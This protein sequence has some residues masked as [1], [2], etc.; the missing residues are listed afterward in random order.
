MSEVV[1]TDQS[2]HEPSTAHLHPLET[3]PQGSQSEGI[4]F[5]HEHH[6]VEVGILA[7]S[8]I[9]LMLL[10]LGSFII[11]WFVVIG[12]LNSLKAH[13]AAPSATY[14][15]RPALKR[16]WPFPPLVAELQP[17]GEAPDLQPEPDKPMVMLREKQEADLDTY[18]W[19]KD[20]KGRTI[21]VTLKIDRAM[22]LALERGLPVEQ[23][24][25]PHILPPTSPVVALG[26]IPAS[27][28]VIR[29]MEL[30]PNKKSEAGAAA[31]H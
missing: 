14:A 31:K 20:E 30:N 27:E 17:V 2:F 15:E 3:I 12:L 5:G 21:G 8:V 22:D 4:E 9:G 25:K 16:A 7:K 28:K 23:K 19:R 6:D 13:D 18:G 24:A 29:E 26:E 1:L 10:I 11:C